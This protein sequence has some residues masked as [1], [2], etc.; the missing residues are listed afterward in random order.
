MC[1]LRGCEFVDRG[2]VGVGVGVGGCGCG[3]G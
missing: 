1:V 2:C 3:C